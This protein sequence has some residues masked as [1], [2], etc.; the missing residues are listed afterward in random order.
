[1]A[2]SSHTKS[3][4]SIDLFNLSPLPDARRQ[5]TMQCKIPNNFFLPDGKNTQ[6]S[7]IVNT[8]T[9]D[10]LTPNGNEGVGVQIDYLEHAYRTR[11]YVVDRVNSKINAIHDDS[12]ELTEFK[13]CFSPFDLD[14]LE[15]KV[16]RLAIGDKYKE[17]VFEPH[18]ALQRCY[19][20][21]NSKTQNMEEL[22]GMGFDENNY[23][24][25][26]PVSKVTS[27]QGTTRPTS[28]PKPTVGTDLNISDP[29]NSRGKINRINSFTTTQEQ[30]DTT[31]KQFK[32]GP[33]KSS[34]IRGHSQPSISTQGETHRPQ[35]ICTAC[36]GMDHLRKDCHEVVFCTRC[37]TRSHATEVCHVP[38]KTVTSNIICIYCGSIDHT[39]GSCH[40]K[41]TDNREEPRSMPR[42][43]RDQKPN[44][45]YNRI[46]A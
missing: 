15:L 12:L 17:D 3:R 20:D 23:S 16:C 38:A 9:F 28:T 32:G 45:T 6:L 11:Y 7:K 27:Q 40:N 31:T 13:G 10:R 26:P 24:P 41:P 4:A 30:M 8:W 5:S 39:S 22:T 2:R 43:L 29:T 18:G 33:V 19:S 36:G 44:K 35:V 25:I 46:V 42:D 1:M 37:R 14:N 21:S 34:A